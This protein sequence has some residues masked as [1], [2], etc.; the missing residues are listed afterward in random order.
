M[1]HMQIQASLSLI[2]SC[3]PSVA[4]AI[5]VR[6]AHVGMLEN[7]HKYSDIFL[8][9]MFLL[10]LLVVHGKE[11]TEQETV[12][13]C[14]RYDFCGAINK[15]DSAQHLP[16]PCCCTDHVTDKLTMAIMSTQGI[17]V[18][19]HGLLGNNFK[20][21]TE[22]IWYYVSESNEPYPTFSDYEVVQ[23]LIKRP[24][25]RYFNSKTSSGCCRS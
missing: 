25:E 18:Y 17:Q 22:T 3:L 5:N 16:S 13:T 12:T 9:G 21:T 23:K 4:T 14:K 19:T 6:R 8:S 1:Q 2:R 15:R 7:D 24:K 20:I 11:N 10:D